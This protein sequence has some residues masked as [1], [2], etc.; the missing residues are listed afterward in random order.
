MNNFKHTISKGLM[1]TACAAMV[2]AP[3][4]VSASENLTYHKSVEGTLTVELIA[5]Y[6]SGA[7]IDAG[8]TEIVA[9]DSHSQRA[10]SVNGDEKALDILDLSG[11][12]NREENISLLKRITLEEIGVKAGDVTSVAIHPN[13]DYIAIAVSAPEKTD[14]G[15]VVFMSV[16]GEALANVEVGALPDM[17]TFT[18]DG[19]KVLVA[20]EGE[21]ADDYS[22]N[23][24]GSVSIIDVSGDINELS[25]EHA[26]EVNFDNETIDES[27][28]KVHPGS[29]YAQDLEP[30][31]ITVDDAGEFA[32][33]ALQEANAMA[34]LDI[35]NRKFISV[36]S[37]GYKDF[38]TSTNMMDASNEDDE[39][40]IQNWPVLSIYQPDGITAFEA[41]GKTYIFSANEGDA[42]DWEAF[43]E[44]ERVG[45]IADQYALN[46]DLYQGYSQEELDQ[47]VE[48]G[49]FDEDQLGRLNT[50]ISHPVNSDG[51]FEAIYGYGGRSFS[52]WDAATLEQVYDSGAE[53]EKLIEEFNPDYFHTDNDEDGFDSRSDDKGVEPESVITGKVD[54]K[55]YAFIGLERQGGIMAYDLANPDVPAFDSYFSSRIFTEDEKAVTEQSGDVAPEGLTFISAEDSPTGKEL[56]LVAHEVSGTIAVYELGQEGGELT[57]TATSTAN[58]L[59]IGSLLIL[60]GSGLI[61][62]RK[63]HLNKSVLHRFCN[64]EEHF[65]WADALPVMGDRMSLL[66]GYADALGVR[67]KIMGGHFLHLNDRFFYSAD[68][69]SLHSKLLKYVWLHSVNPILEIPGILCW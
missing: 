27:I 33:V 39:I 29:A 11:L 12:K 52:V 13:G 32:Y 36:K 44:E 49:L 53:F 48:D 64:D 3:L 8:G 6:S 10:F 18:P 46:A 45:D 38:S 20:N 4:S 14:A 42:Q 37:L 17:L 22:F 21:P 58:Y 26:V 34:K 1:A 62:R 50:S 9:Y 63:F 47:M 40:A 66:G 5:R 15:H 57:D 54:E 35:A 41:D 60:L 2:A 65:Y 7:E 51:Q 24:E 30:E 43:S 61:Y 55:N 59:L 68:R 16:D 19:T 25:D 56:L 23:P 28:R 67:A 31:Y 69:L